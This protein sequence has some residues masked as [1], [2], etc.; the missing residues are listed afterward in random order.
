VVAEIRGRLD[1]VRHAAE[2]LPRRKTMFVVGRSPGAI[3]DI[4]AVGKG[5]FLNELISIAGGVNLFEIAASYYPNIPREEIY[6]GSPE[7]VIDMGDMG[8]TD[9]VEPGRRA[10]IVALWRSELPKLPAVAEGRVY[11]VA[12]DIFV[13][14]G[15]RVVEAAEALLRMIHP[16]SGR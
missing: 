4:V 13:V 7:V 1:A 9:A 11:A 14:P 5:A 6:A 12:D 15:P 3:G 2:G 8:D 10:E 16:E